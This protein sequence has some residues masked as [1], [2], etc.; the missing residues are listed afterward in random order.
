MSLASAGLAK[1]VFDQYALDQETLA[2]TRQDRLD[3][4]ADRVTEQAERGLRRR[5]MEQQEQ[6][7][8]MQLEK[9]GAEMKD[10][11]QG[12]QLDEDIR[13]DF[14]TGVA[15]RAQQAQS[16]DDAN[17]GTFPPAA[18]PATPP[19]EQGVYND[20]LDTPRYAQDPVARKKLLEMR[21]TA[22]KEGLNEVYNA[23]TDDATPS[24]LAKVFNRFGNDY[25]VG[26]E[27]GV[28]PKTGE[29]TLV[30]IK[31][32]G[33][34]GQPMTRRNVGLILG[35][36]KPDETIVTPDGSTLNNKRTG[37][38]LFENKKEDPNKGANDRERQKQ[39]DSDLE[40]IKGL[41]MA[42]AFG[43]DQIS[44]LTG[45]DKDLASKAQSLAGELYDK[46]IT[47][48][49]GRHL[50]NGEIADISAR[51]A[52]GQMKLGDLTPK[53]YKLS[54]VPKAFRGAQQPTAAAMSGNAPGAAPAAAA[55]AGQPLVVQSTIKP[56]APPPG[57]PADGK[58]E[59]D[60]SGTGWRYLSPDGK[61]AWSPEAGPAVPQPPAAT[62]PIAPRPTGAA[63]RPAAPAAAPDISNIPVPTPSPEFAQ[64]PVQT[65]P[66]PP[67]RGLARQPARVMPTFP[68]I[69]PALPAAV[70]DAI[71]PRVA[72]EPL[73][74]PRSGLER[75]LP[76]AP[77]KP[78]IA[79]PSAPDAEPSD[80]EMMAELAA[81]PIYPPAASESRPNPGLA[82]RQP[83]AQ[84]GMTPE[85]DAMSRRRAD[86]ELAGLQK[87]GA[88][89]LDARDRAD[90]DAAMDAELRDA[91]PAGASPKARGNKKPA[92]A[93][94]L[95][96]REQQG[97][98][99]TMPE[100]PGKMDSFRDVPAPPAKGYIEIR[101]PGVRG[102]DD[103]VYQWYRFADGTLGYTDKRWSPTKFY[104][105]DPK[106]PLKLIREHDLKKPTLGSQQDAWTEFAK[107]HG[108][109]GAK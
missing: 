100:K 31:P 11:R 67:A 17:D 14:S 90:R 82:R 26:A 49:T 70:E 44:H 99:Q 19:T 9:Q 68:E 62:T 101:P 16:F 42:G 23:W 6:V 37:A 56:A 29:K 89:D 22:K 79:N 45:E 106:S 95:A 39:Y 53:G 73:P 84:Q 61:S 93:K 66:E 72:A 94:G 64:Q 47:D 46:G 15:K 28:D 20:I 21:D 77:A 105:M 48:A 24:Q 102:K 96:K 78:A 35:L 52:R 32:D 92:P 2:N 97:A 25:V 63:P 55:P 104:E 5:A 80:P 69:R 8:T 40:A 10:W 50:T 57:A 86:E 108:L 107:Q 30:G 109:Q 91:K 27:F 60:P 54:G 88:A 98:A 58:W 7:N 41:H 81:S 13:N 51:I 1:R 85:E 43:K 103:P 3:K 65:Q 18:I 33:T 75:R 34:R 74:A 87:P 59:A 71:N 83:A 4:Q 38:V 12:R 76:A 36:E